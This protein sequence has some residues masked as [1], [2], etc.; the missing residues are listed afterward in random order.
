MQLTICE[1]VGLSL[2]YVIQMTFG[3]KFEMAGEEERARIV[4][5]TFHLRQKESVMEKERDR[6]KRLL[7]QEKEKR[8]AVGTYLLFLGHLF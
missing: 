1:W 6:K 4:S 5:L 2:P 8:C 7:K 3:L